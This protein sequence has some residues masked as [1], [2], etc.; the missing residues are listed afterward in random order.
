V[1]APDMTPTIL[2]LAGLVVTEQVK[3]QVRTQHLQC[4]MFTNE[5]WTFDPNST[6][7][8]SVV[9]LINGQVDKIRDIAVC[10]NTIVHQTPI[11]AKSAIVTEDGWCLHYAGAYKDIEVGGKM[12]TNQLVD[13]TTK[14]IT[15]DPMLF[16]DTDD[17]NETTDVIG[18]HEALARDIHERYVGWLEENGTAEQYVAG[19]RN[20]R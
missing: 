8:R 14:R 4:G 6:H 9:P 18:H 19:R 17:P 12:Y 7:G 20:L 1:Q 13:L 16:C 11:L 3:G 2:E 15:T 5:E 10:S